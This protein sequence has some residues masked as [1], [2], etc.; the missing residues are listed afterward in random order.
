MF[1]TQTVV[2]SAARSRVRAAMF[3]VAV[4]CLLLSTTLITA[5]AAQ[6]SPLIDVKSIQQGVRSARKEVQV[7]LANPAAA[8]ETYLTTFAAV[9]A[10]RGHPLP[11]GPA[12]SK[13]KAERLAIF[14]ENLQKTAVR[15]ANNRNKLLAYGITPFMHLTQ[16][17]YEVKVC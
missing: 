13:T 14:V 4:L 11:G 15:N 10:P 16:Q 6:H 17:E 1:I 7:A 9:S 8:F 12:D 3:L 2:C 5:Q